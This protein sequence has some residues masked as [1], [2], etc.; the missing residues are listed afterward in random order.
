MTDIK[1]PQMFSNPIDRSS[2]FIKPISTNDV[3]Q[4][5]ELVQPWEYH[6]R[7]LDKGDNFT[8][9]IDVLISNEL[10]I[11]SVDFNNILE[12]TGSPPEGMRTFWIPADDAQNIFLRNNL[13]TGDKMGL[14]PAGAEL[15]SNS[16]P[17][18]KISTISIPENLLISRSN[19]LGLDWETV[20]K[21]SYVDFMTIPTESTRIIRHLIRELFNLKKSNFTQEEVKSQFVYLKKRLIDAFLLASTQHHKDIL[22]DPSPSNRLRVFKSFKEYIYENAHKPYVSG[23]ICSIV[24]TSE[25]TLQ[26]TIKAFTGLSPAQFYKNMKL[27]FVREKLIQNER[28]ISKVSQLANEFGFWHSSQFATDY[29][30]HFGELPSE[31]LI[32]RH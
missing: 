8:G 26:Y 32:F 25:R 9:K 18:C 30:N 12:Q 20:S 28:D 23:D 11:F 15:D 2:F 6:L 29:R 16:L 3:D 27:S 14:F 17:G 13:I 7:K 22:F 10:L 24:G 31:T 21:S 5:C 19:N 1:I 4:L